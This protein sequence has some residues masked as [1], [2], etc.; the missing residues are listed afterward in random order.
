MKILKIFARYTKKLL[1]AVILVVVLTLVLNYVR[2]LI[3][4]LIG[5]VFAILGQEQESTLPGF[6]NNLF[7]DKTIIQQLIMVFVC[8]ICTAFVRDLLNV[9]S[10]YMIGFTS[11]GI[12]YNIQTDFYNHVQELPY[13]YLNHAETGDLIQRSTSDISRV[14]RFIGGSLP[15]MLSSIVQISIYSI[16]MLIIDV[17]LGGILLCMLPIILIIAVVYFRWMAPVFTDIEEKEG[18]LTTVI[19][20]NL[21]GIRVVKAF[22]N[23]DLE[24]EKCNKS[25]KGFVGVWKKLMNRM[26]TYW[27]SGDFMSY[28]FMLLAFILGTVFIKNGTITPSGTITLPKVISIFLYVQYIMWPT[29]NLGR[30]IGE[31]GRT[32]IAS[33]RI[34]EIVDMPTEFTHDVGNLEPEIK[35]NIEFKDVSFQFN[36]SKFAT[37][38]DINLEIKQGET[39]ALIGRTG[40]GK[41]TLV[42]MLNRMLDS[43]GGTIMIDGVNIRDINK[44]YLRKNVG[45]VLQEPFLFSR[46]IA[47]NIG[48]ILDK[49][50]MQKIKYVSEIAAVDSDIE[51]FDHG[52]DTLVGERGVT[53]SGGQK[54]RISIARTLV[55][56]KP[57]LVFD[58]SLSAVDTETDV[59]IRQALKERKTIT[60]TIIITH[61]ITTAMDADKIVV[62]EDG[63]ISEVGTH[64]ELIHREGLY[65]NIWDIQNYFDAEKEVKTDE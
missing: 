17:K 41:S 15:Q 29:R 33:S 34:L 46:T 30:L 60:T 36:D 62:L 42:S 56:N 51:R 32:N 7:N 5:K 4:L 19:Q 31:M 53:L 26:S 14:K 61:R 57:I 12:G 25:M 23:E 54:Q 8:V 37:L 35:G 59:K 65:K 50:D 24:V 39:V 45:I 1:W 38:K 55:E 28:L 21:T 48:V 27:A 52:Y 20:E 49:N 16:Q 40:S 64:E 58:D 47:D 3:P 13:S 10:D 11:E 43:T 2:S 9:G 18:K 63:M 22:A 6:I 44:K